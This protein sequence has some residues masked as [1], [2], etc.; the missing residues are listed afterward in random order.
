MLFS[1]ANRQLGPILGNI[2]LI[3][4]NLINF[5]D[6]MP[7]AIIKKY[8]KLKLNETQKAQSSSTNEATVGGGQPQP[9][10]N[11]FLGV[12]SAKLNAGKLAKGIHKS[13]YD[14]IMVSDDA[15]V[16]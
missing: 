8:H 16:N 4:P 5:D 10:P 9:G 12:L 6:T 14:E 3:M 11:S 13:K 7:V 1:M 15:N 2:K